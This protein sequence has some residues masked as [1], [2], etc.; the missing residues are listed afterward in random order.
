[1]AVDLRRP[2]GACLGWL[3]RTL[4]SL[5]ARGVIEATEEHYPP[6]F[7]VAV[8]PQRYR[9]YLASRGLPTPARPGAVVVY[10]VRAGDSLWEIAH[11]RGTTVRHLR[12]LNHL[13]D[14]LI[15]PGQRLRVPRRGG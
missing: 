9:G 2:H 12:T 11:R 6:H 10:R 15:I 8:Y 14:D 5:E 4:R 13:S 7:H 3:R 1:M